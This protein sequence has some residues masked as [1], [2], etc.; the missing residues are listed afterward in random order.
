[1]V[2]IRATAA[3]LA[4]LSACLLVTDVSAV[5][6]GCC[7]SYMTS[8]IPFSRIKGYSVQTMKEMCSINAIIFHTMKG[9]GCTD[10]ALNWVMQYVNRL[11]DKAQQVHANTSKANQ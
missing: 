6:Y 8:R 5:N 9:K 4:L 11:R 2:S 1:M 7:R 10:P 3:V